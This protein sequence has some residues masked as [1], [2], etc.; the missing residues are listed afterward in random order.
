MRA[1]VVLLL[2]AAALAEPELRPGVVDLKN[3][4]DPVNGETAAEAV[5]ADWNGIRVRFQTAENAAAFLEKPK[6]HLAKLGVKPVEVEGKPPLLSLENATCPVTGEPAKREHPADRGGVRVFC[7]TADAAKAFPK[8]PAKH[9]G[10]LKLGW[11]PPVVDLNN[12]RCPV[13]GD[14]CY[15]EAPIWV[16][17]E[18]IRVRVCCDHCVEEF[19]ADPVRCYRALMVDPKALKKKFGLEK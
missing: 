3:A 17:H 1:L 14:A 4:K 7:A 12:T 16:D 15:P 13:T 8:D 10:A 9:Y 5:T 2:A 11:V 6:E 19:E 18:G